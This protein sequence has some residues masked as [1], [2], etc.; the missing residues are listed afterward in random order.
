MVSGPTGRAVG[1]LTNKK[2][3]KKKIMKSLFFP[4]SI[5]DCEGPL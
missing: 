2:K 3:N 4:I 5:C 1:H